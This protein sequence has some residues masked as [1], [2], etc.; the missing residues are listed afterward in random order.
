MA[1]IYLP[2][3]CFLLLSHS[4]YL[5]VL[6]IFCF[7]ALLCLTN[8]FVLIVVGHQCS[9]GRP[10]GHV[11]DC[12]WYLERGNILVVSVSFHHFLIIPFQDITWWC[13]ILQIFQKR[14]MKRSRNSNNCSS[15][16]T[17]F[18]S[19]HSLISH[20]WVI[21]P[22]ILS[23]SPLLNRVNLMCVSL[24]FSGD[25]DTIFDGIHENILQLQYHDP[26]MQKTVKPFFLWFYLI[27]I[28]LML[29]IWYWFCNTIFE[30]IHLLS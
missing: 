21:P 19:L 9:S 22:N 12:F 4:F 29:S 30:W 7:F 25:Y 2:S 6:F 3:Q 17:D 23:F 14:K 15:S 20:R 28:F 24:M 11:K 5:F 13:Y 1:L 26:G 8:I 10:E 18:D 27:I 16:S